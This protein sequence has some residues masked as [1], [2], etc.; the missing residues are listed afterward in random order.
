MDI[1]GKETLESMLADFAGSVLFVSHDRYF[2]K[3]VASKVLDFTKEGVV[4]YNFGYEEY[5]EKK[6][7]KPVEI[8]PTKVEK[9]EEKT[10]EKPVYF[11][12]GKER[13]KL[14]RKLEKIEEK[15]SLLE[16]EITKLKDELLNPAISSDFTK[17]SKIQSDIDEKEEILLSAM[18]EWNEAD[19]QLSELK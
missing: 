8:R 13:S 15:I 4:A 2:I 16:D 9:V 6:L 17:L 3:K 1:V 5:E 18:E 7:G 14:E 12:L 10:Q 11:N 19:K